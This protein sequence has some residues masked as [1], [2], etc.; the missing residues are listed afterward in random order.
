MTTSNSN[1]SQ[2]ETIKILPVLEAKQANSG[3]ITVVG[4]VISRSMTF[5]TISKSEWV[6]NNISC[7]DHGSR[8]FDPPLMYT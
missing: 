1:S 2:T 6:C 4:M 5:K 7:A 8:A 3:K